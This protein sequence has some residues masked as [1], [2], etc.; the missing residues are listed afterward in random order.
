MSASLVDTLAAH[1]SAAIAAALGKPATQPADAQLRASG[2][3]RH[4]DYQCNAAMALAK[5]AGAKPRELAERIVAA[6]TPRLDKMVQP[7]EIAGPGFINIRLSDAYLGRRLD[8]IPPADEPNGDRV[9]IPPR[10]APQTVVVDYSSPNIAKQMHV[11]HLRSTII[12][13]VLARVLAFE[14]H[15]VIRQNHVGD[16]GTQ[17]G[18]LIAYYEDRQGRPGDALPHAADHEDVLAAIED[19]YRAANERFKSDAAFAEKARLAV[20]RLQSGDARAREVWQAVCRA[21][22]EAFTD[23][24]R[25]LGVLLSPADVCGESFYNDRLSPTIE[26][27]R[28]ALPPRENP[29]AGSEWAE[30]RDD[31]GAVCVFFH[32]A[33]GQ[34]A[35]KNPDGQPLPL[36]VRKSDGAYLYASTD[37]AAIRYRV[38]ELGATRILYVVGAP[39]K[40]HLEMVFK[41]AQFA[42][43]LGAD[44]TLEHV[45]FGQVLGEDRKLLR[46]RTGS[47]IKLRELLDEGEQRAYELLTQRERDAA[48]QADNAEQAAVALSDDEKRRI[49]R[50]VGI[51]SVKYA[52]L[53]RDRNGDYVFSWEKM[54]AMQGNTAPYMLYAYARIRS[55]YRK[56]AERFGKPD[57]PATRDVESDAETETRGG[58]AGASAVRISAAGANPNCAASSGAN[59]NRAGVDLSHSTERAL[60]LRLLRFH[61]TLD[62]VAA[63]LLPHILCSYLYELAADFM[64]F[65][66]ACPVLAAES[67]AT[68]ASRLRL[69]DLAAR[70]LRVGLGL[71]G[72]E[73]IERM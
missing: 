13:D 72:L 11:G 28:R 1:F 30:V 17:F 51:G 62:A 55:I 59:A 67:P 14:G 35:F 57:A 65:Y 15:R 36:I 5:A 43:W 58:A 31:Q 69:C 7:L 68:R 45:S 48:A 49:A 70:T 21:S 63:E 39:T 2:D 10:K 41:A 25:R 33:D 54:L 3:A 12:G 29:P 18:M 64:R 26:A 61:E 23:I 42:G 27:L 46:T 6:V 34:P 22:E 37:L 4:G 9:G 16:W 71:L 19:D 20:G 66:E 53:A 47:A 50:A 56:A 8:E 24:Y 60:A 52:D 40:L 32:D 73:T 44:V 38:G